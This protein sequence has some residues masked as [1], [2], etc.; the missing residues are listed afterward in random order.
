[1]TDREIPWW[2]QAGDILT[3]WGC[4]LDL[5]HPKSLGSSKSWGAECRLSLSFPLPP[6]FGDTVESWQPE[7]VPVSHDHL[8]SA[9]R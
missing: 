9:W 3:F 6:R 1:M 5:A 7:M 2:A 8:Q 4:H